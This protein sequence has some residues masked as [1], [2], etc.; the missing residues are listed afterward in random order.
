MAISAT[1]IFE[2]HPECYTTEVADL[3]RAGRDPFH[4]PGLHF[5]REQAESIALNGIHGGFVIMAGSGMCTGGRVRSG[6][7]R[8]PLEH[9]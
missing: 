7:G 5:A 6:M 8:H 1:Q 2:H 9:S 3:L 4:F